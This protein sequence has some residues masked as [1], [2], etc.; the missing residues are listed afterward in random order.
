M[1]VGT[2]IITDREHAFPDSVALV[3]RTTTTG[4][5]IATT[6]NNN[7]LR[8]PSHIDADSSIQVSQT[9]LT[10]LLWQRP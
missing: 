8:D 10:W 3:Q 5:F 6:G 9:T 1:N 2:H 7:S 4:T